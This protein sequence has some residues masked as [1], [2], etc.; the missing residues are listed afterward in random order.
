[1]SRSFTEKSLRFDFDDDWK[2]C[3]RW[4]GTIEQRYEIFKGRTPHCVD[5]VGIDAEG[6]LYLIEVKDHSRNLRENPEPWADVLREKVHDTLMGVITAHRRGDSSGLC[7]P[8]AMALVKKARV[9]VV[10]HLEEPSWNVPATSQQRRAVNGA[11]LRREHEHDFKWLSARFRVVHRGNC[12]ELIP[13]LSV[14]RV[15]NE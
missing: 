12:H 4:D 11:V 6:T 7:G 1:M 15:V 3:G 14:R 13:G 2:V 9:V 5:L 10:L 8:L